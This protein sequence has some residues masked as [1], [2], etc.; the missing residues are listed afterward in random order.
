MRDRAV[1]SLPRTGQVRRDISFTHIAWINNNS[2]EDAHTQKLPCDWEQG[3]QMQT[4]L[5]RDPA[6]PLH[7]CLALTE[8]WYFPTFQLPYLESGVNHFYFLNLEWKLN[9]IMD[10]KCFLRPKKKRVQWMQALSFWS[11]STR[12]INTS[13]MKLSSPQVCGF[14]CI[15]SSL[16]PGNHAF[17]HHWQRA[18]SPGDIWGLVVRVLC[19][20]CWPSREQ[21]VSLYEWVARLP[22]RTLK[23]E[24]EAI[25][26]NTRRQ[27]SCA[28]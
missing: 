26:N 12:I 13:S 19:G 11:N 7:R 10:L 15:Q 2:M 16:S 20:A 25:T 9:E 1:G 6:W 22:E 17:W 24:R 3:V 27:R 21:G 23:T 5:G 28:Q 18:P 4:I 8:W 14:Y